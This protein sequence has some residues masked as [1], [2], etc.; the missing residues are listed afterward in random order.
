MW[1]ELETLSAQSPSRSNMARHA[2]AL[3]HDGKHNAWAAFQ[4][5]LWRDRRNRALWV[6]V[7]SF[8][9]G[10]QRPESARAAG[11]DLRSA[12]DRAEHDLGAVSPAA[13]ALA[14]RAA[15]DGG[16]RRR[17]AGLPGPPSERR[18]RRRRAQVADR[19]RGGAE[20]L[21]RRPRHRADRGW[22]GPRRAGSPAQSRRGA[23][24]RRV[25]ARGE[26]RAC[27]SRC[28]A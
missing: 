7:G 15:V 21:D 18:A 1:D 19:L 23:G 2:A 25:V 20:E 9:G 27:A 10:V 12:V 24:A 5:A 28:C 4:D 16:R 17:S 26:S 11:V 8:Y 6:L 14:R 22:R 3:V 13:D